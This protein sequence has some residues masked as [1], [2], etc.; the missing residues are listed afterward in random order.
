MI[1]APLLLSSS[2]HPLWGPGVLLLRGHDWKEKNPALMFHLASLHLHLGGGKW[3]RGTEMRHQIRLV[4]SGSRLCCYTTQQQISMPSPS[5]PLPLPSP[6]NERWSLSQHLKRML[7]FLKQRFL[8][9]VLLFCVVRNVPLVL[10][11][12]TYLPVFWIAFRLF[13]INVGHSCCKPINLF[14]F[15]SE[16]LICF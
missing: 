9:H 15:Q 3:G 5:L 14:L 8:F 16:F 10:S 12:F 13:S 1:P 2:L 11:V 4:S 6:Q 7:L